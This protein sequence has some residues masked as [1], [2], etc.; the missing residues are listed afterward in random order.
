MLFPHNMTC[1]HWEKHFLIDFS[2]SFRNQ[3]EPSV[4]CARM[5]KRITKVYGFFMARVR[6]KA[7]P[8]LWAHAINELSC[9]IPKYYF[10]PIFISNF[11][12]AGFP[13]STYN[14]ELFTLLLVRV[15]GTFPCPLTWGR[16]AYRRPY[17]LRKL[18]NN[19][20]KC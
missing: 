18:S 6:R 11:F 12:P 5:Y 9:S 4:H 17:F 15:L 7:I 3:K 2:F 19:K 8:T 16:K 14:T 1:A 20:K 13:F 10:F